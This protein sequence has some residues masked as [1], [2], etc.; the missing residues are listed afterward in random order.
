MAADQ[1]PDRPDRFEP[2]CRKRRPKPYP[3]MTQ[4]RRVLKA[5]GLDSIPVKNRRQA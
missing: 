2:R 4:P 3:L 5:A 1:L